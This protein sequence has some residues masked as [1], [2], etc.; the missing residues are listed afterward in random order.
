MICNAAATATTITTITTTTT[1]NDADTGAG[2]R[3]SLL[4]S[5]KNQNVEDSGAGDEKDKHGINDVNDIPVRVRFA[6]QVAWGEVRALRKVI[7]FAESK[8]RE[9]RAGGLIYPRDK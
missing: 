4:E 9:V 7:A 6:L 2:A 3:E 5:L 8:L 1:G